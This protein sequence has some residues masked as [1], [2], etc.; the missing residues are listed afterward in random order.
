VVISVKDYF[1]LA[2]DNSMTITAY[3]SR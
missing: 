1:S 2:I 3:I